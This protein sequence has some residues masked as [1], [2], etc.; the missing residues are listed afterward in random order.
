MQLSREYLRRAG[1][2][3]ALRPDRGDAATSRADHGSTA[4]Q[5]PDLQPDVCLQEVCSA[6][7]PVGFQGGWLARQAAGEDQCSLKGVLCRDL[8][9]LGRSRRSVGHA[10]ELH[11]LRL[12]VSTGMDLPCALA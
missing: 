1:P 10:E 12:N 7:V 8:K 6:Q 11:A 2:V 5:G 3:A 9:V 4:P